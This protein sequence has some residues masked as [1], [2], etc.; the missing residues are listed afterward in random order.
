M[1]WVEE[2]C[3]NKQG[4]KS[5]RNS[6]PS[7]RQKPVSVE[8][9]DSAPPP[10]V[11]GH[12]KLTMWKENSYFDLNT[13]T[14][15]KGVINI[16]ECKEMYDVVGKILFL[17]GQG[18]QSPGRKAYNSA[19]LAKPGLEY[20]RKRN[21]M[22]KEW[23]YDQTNDLFNFDN[24]DL[25][26]QPLGV[27][28]SD[29]SAQ[30]A[31]DVLHSL[32][33]PKPEIYA[34][35]IIL[36]S[37]VVIGSE[38]DSKPKP[39]ELNEDTNLSESVKMAINCAKYYQKLKPGNTH[40]EFDDGAC[41]ENSFKC[42]DFLITRC[43]GAAAGGA[44]ICCALRH[45][46]QSSHTP[47]SDKN[48]KDV[49]EK[50]KAALEPE[51]LAPILHFLAGGVQSLISYPQD[52]SRDITK[53]KLM[54]FMIL[55]NQ[56]IINKPI[57]ETVWQRTQDLINNFLTQALFPEGINKDICKKGLPTA[58][59]VWAQREILRWNLAHAIKLDFDDFCV[60]HQA[61]HP[62][63]SSPFHLPSNLRLLLDCRLTP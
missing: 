33:N 38:T 47:K 46:G 35:Q 61:E 25:V 50:L 56:L 22:L 20:V 17:R 18:A 28:A 55:L 1:V 40:L 8:N 14:G 27:T 34:A 2:Q 58:V 42:L 39:M 7:K 10:L 52:F 45:F 16:D 15:L 63:K 12:D 4:K 31:R 29:D 43:Y 21:M 5:S 3:N 53:T 51:T 19:E 36:A 54:H 32:N 6:N 11:L 24:I 13:Q 9:P 37:V 41:T 60:N 44:S 23:V 26:K 59:N 57:T 62:D 48:F 30:R 49:T